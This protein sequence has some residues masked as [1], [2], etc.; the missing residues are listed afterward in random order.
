A[1][2]IASSKVEDNNLEVF[3]PQVN[4]YI[5]QIVGALGDNNNQNQKSN[6]SDMWHA[7]KILEEDEIVIG[8]LAGNTKSKILQ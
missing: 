7:I 2:K 8:K 1:Q 4:N 6:S 3:S 5:T